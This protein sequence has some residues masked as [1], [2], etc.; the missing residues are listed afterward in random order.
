[1]LD[2]LPRMRRIESTI[3]RRPGSATVARMR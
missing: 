1:L 3:I 2:C